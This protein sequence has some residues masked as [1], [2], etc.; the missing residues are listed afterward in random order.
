MLALDVRLLTLEREAGSARR[1][2]DL[3]SEL[4]GPTRSDR[5]RCG[6]EHENV[7]AEAGSR[8]A[9]ARATAQPPAS[10]P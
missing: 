5:V 8:V 10:P 9:L 7:A 1:S 3:R 6:W 2:R 4:S